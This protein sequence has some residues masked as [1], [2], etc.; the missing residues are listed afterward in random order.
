MGV[1][2]GP[3]KVIQP[4][5]RPKDPVHFWG[6]WK[7]DPCCHRPVHESLLGKQRPK[8]PVLA[9]ATVALYQRSDRRFGGAQVAE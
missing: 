7:L 1:K 8:R 9:E 2:D 5:R 4:N 3:S 6:P